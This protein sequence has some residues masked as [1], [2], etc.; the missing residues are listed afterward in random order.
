MHRGFGLAAVVAATLLTGC[1]AQP[2]QMSAP[3]ATAA[4]ATPAASAF[5]DACWKPSD[6][7][8]VEEEGITMK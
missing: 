6:R 3:A 5:V 7:T 8:T 1:G 4:T 2:A